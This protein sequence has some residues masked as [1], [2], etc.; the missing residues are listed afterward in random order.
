Y[1]HEYIQKSKTTQNGRTSKVIGSDANVGVFS[2]GGT[3]ALNDSTSVVTNLGM[4]LTD[5][6]SDISL[7]FRMPF[8][9]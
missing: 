6:A 7:S 5:D 9:L 4:G 3:Y 2:I 1:S 8:Q